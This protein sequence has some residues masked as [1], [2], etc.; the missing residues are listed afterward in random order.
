MPNGN[1]QDDFARI[2]APAV[3]AVQR[4][5][6]DNFYKRIGVVGKTAFGHHAS[7]ALE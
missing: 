5:G 1:A 3:R 4:L 6:A 7:C 2:A